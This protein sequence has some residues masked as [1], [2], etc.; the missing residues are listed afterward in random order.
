MSMRYIAE[1]YG[2]RLTVNTA[3]ELYC[4]NITIPLPDGF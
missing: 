3:G 2:G 1:S 4:L